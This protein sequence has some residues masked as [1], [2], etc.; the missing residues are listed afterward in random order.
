MALWVE[1]TPFQRTPSTHAA[2]DLKLV[3]R[4]NVRRLPHITEG[5]E[6]FY[7]ILSPVSSN[8]KTAFLCGNI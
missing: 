8:T 1:K 2:F 7:H 5:S 3:F 4:N 6:Q